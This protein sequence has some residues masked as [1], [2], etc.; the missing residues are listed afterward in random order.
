MSTVENLV[1]LIE[2]KTEEREK[3]IIGDAETDRFERIKLVKDECDIRAARIIRE[4]RKELAADMRR[5]EAS[6]KLKA[7]QKVLHAKTAIIQEILDEAMDTVKDVVKKKTY[8]KIV[9]QLAVEGGVMLKSENLELVFPKGQ[10]PSITAAVVAKAVSK[11]TG[12][13]I[14]VKISKDTVR[15]IGG[16]IVRTTDGLKT[17]DNTFE[18]RFERM[19][20]KIRTEIFAKLFS[21]GK[22][23]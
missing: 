18:G 1:K 9:M 2:S 22:T 15:S 6:T 21:A 19:E 23:K 10:K 17:V 7:K 3:K 13:K 4:A 5:Y 20:H 14:D 11:E 12:Q 8:G 16:V